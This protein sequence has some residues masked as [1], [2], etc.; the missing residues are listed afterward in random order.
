MIVCFFFNIWLFSRENLIQPMKLEPDGQ[1]TK[2]NP[3]DF[4]KLSQQG[5][6]TQNDSDSEVE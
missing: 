3:D 1:M 4:T 6:I 5:Q 2:L